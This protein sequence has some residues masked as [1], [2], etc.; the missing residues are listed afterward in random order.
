MLNIQVS[1]LTLYLSSSTLGEYN[2][3]LNAKLKLAAVVP[4]WKMTI[5][6]TIT[7]VNWSVYIDW[8]ETK[9]WLYQLN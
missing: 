8:Q 2:P 5:S 3:L 7:L 1:R 9:F 6:D 4:P